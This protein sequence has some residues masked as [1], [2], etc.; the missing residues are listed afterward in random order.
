[1]TAHL[2]RG[3][4]RMLPLADKSVQLIVT[5]PPY[6][7]LRSYGGQTSIW[8][9]DPECS[10]SLENDPMVRPMTGGTGAASKKQVTNAG[11]QFGN[12]WVEVDEYHNRGDSSAGPKQKSNLGAVTGRGAVRFATCKLCGAWRGELGGEKNVADFIAH[13]IEVFREC[14]RVL[15]NDGVMFINIGDSYGGSGKGPTT[16]ASTLMNGRGVAA[17]TKVVTRTQQLRQGFTDRVTSGRPKS[18][19][20]VPERLAIALADDG[21]VIRSRIAW[22]K[23]APMPESAK[24]RPTSAWEHLWMVTKQGR[25]FYDADAVRQDSTS[26]EQ[27]EHNQRYAKVY[28]ASDANAEYRQP[29]NVNS[30]GIHSRPGPGGANLR[31]FWLLSPD[32]YAGQHFATFPRELVRRC[33][34]AG[35]SEYGACVACGAPWR[36]T[37]ETEYRRH[38]KWFGHKQAARHSRGS[39]GQS[40][41]E[42][43]VTRT[44]GW[45]TTCKCGS[46]AGVRPC[47]VLDPFAGSFTAPFVAAQLGRTGIGVELS[48]D[49]IAQARYG[50][51]SQEFLPFDTRQPLAGP[52]LTDQERTTA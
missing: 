27:D 48:P 9:G 46:A 1:M 7:N 36:R 4:A 14:G 25:Y 16:A 19:S 30:L 11:S 32:P 29:G 3:D 2:V 26:P 10:H 35:S 23:K 8:G 33:V 40:Y 38:E 18:L 43:I 49:Y 31:N 20:L 45:A 47:I 22:C 6:M 39:A 15:R 24:D 37:T 52:I 42:P 17:G 5:S 21:W 34:S 51:L 28:E 50:R 44:T 41:N 13:L 12:A